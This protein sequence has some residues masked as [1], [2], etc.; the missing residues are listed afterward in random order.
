MIE[1]STPEHKTN[2]LLLRWFANHISSPFAYFFFTKG[3]RISF[4][5]EDRVEKDPDFLMPRLDYF[6][7]KL[8]YRIYS[9]ANKPYEKWGTMYKLDLEAMKKAWGNDN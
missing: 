3:L 5:Y 4:K 2:N 6:R 8:H 9:F 7:L 1:F